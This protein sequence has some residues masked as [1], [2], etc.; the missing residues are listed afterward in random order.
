MLT[1]RSKPELPSDYTYKNRTAAGQWCHCLQSFQ[2]VRCHYVRSETIPAQHERRLVDTTILSEN[3]SIFRQ[4]YYMKLPLSRLH[5]SISLCN[6]T[7]STGD[8]MT[9]VINIYIFCLKWPKFSGTF[10]C[11]N[12][13]IILMFAPHCIDFSPFQL[14]N[15]A[16]NLNVLPHS[17]HRQQKLIKKRVDATTAYTMGTTNLMASNTKSSRK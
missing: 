1:I 12:I 10:R 11:S 4:I 13:R 16:E 15:N 9:K 3:F 14:M 5:S 17:D 2:L 6:Q 8:E 7:F